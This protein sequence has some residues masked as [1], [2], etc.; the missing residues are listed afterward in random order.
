M[1]A[2]APAV[3]SNATHIHTGEVA[4]KTTMRDEPINR[5]VPGTAPETRPR[6]DI[7]KSVLEATASRANESRTA[8]WSSQFRPV[9]SSLLKTVGSYTPEQQACHVRFFDEHVAP[10]MG[11][12]PT[13]TCS[14][15]LLTPNG[16]PF[17]VSINLSD[18]GN[19]CVRFTFEPYMPKSTGCEDSPLSSIAEAVGA[20]MRW[21]RQFAEEF[22]ETQEERE[23]LLRKMPKDTMSIPRCILAF[24][25][26][27]GDRTMKAY[28]YPVIKSIA[29][30]LNSDEA[31]INLLKRLES[32]GES[33]VRGLEYIEDW[34]PISQTPATIQVIGTDCI[35]PTAGARVKIYMHPDNTFDSVRDHVTFGG[36]RSDKTTIEGLRILREMWHLLLGEPQG[37]VSDS[38]PKPVNVPKSGHKG[39]CLSWELRPGQE[40]P[41]VKVY[42]PLFQYYST[43]RAIAK[44]LG[45]A[46]KMRGWAWGIDGGY[47]DIIEQAL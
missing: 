36:K 16:S 6:I 29:A 31:S 25:L 39:M 2:P 41:D 47:E 35:D 14:R 20:D 26:H 3:L 42:V 40:L 22:F 46:F 17:E 9:L 1:M 4:A 10:N 32:G 13:R 5:Y 30:G 28:F 33:F 18:A 21:A 34:R 45:N 38:L 23:A 19:P 44:N 43:D 8:F 12:V 24:D 15:S 7:C 37:N 27:G 11:P